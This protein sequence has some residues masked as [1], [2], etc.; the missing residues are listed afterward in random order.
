MFLPYNAKLNIL[1]SNTINLQIF[2]YRF[3]QEGFAHV[4]IGK[5]PSLPQ[6]HNFTVQ[7]NIDL[8]QSMQ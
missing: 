1:I 4:L 2:Y 5:E 7:G 8:I 3:S 6:A